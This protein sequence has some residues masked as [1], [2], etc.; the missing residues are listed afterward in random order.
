MDFGEAGV[1]EEGVKFRGVE[2][3]PDVG[4]EFAGLL[5]AVLEEV[6]DDDASAGARDPKCFAHGAGGLLRVV[7]R[8]AEKGE[9]HF[10]IGDGRGFEIAEA[11]FEIG[12][13]VL[14][15]DAR[16]ERDH[17]LRIVHSDDFL[18]PAREELGKITFACAEVGDDL[19]R[20]EEQEGFGES[21]PTAPGTIAAPE[22][23]GELIEVGARGV[24]AIPQGEI[25]RLAVTAGFG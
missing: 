3:E 8:L 20:H 16:A 6:E 17:F 15:G 9:V 1:V 25:E 13:A 12:E 4:V 21:F 19:P 22:F 14:R 5:E 23:P 11:V 10:A 24:R 7:Q 18:R 2:A